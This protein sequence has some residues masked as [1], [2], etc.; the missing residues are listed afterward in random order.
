MT[1]PMAQI[2]RRPSLWLAAMLMV[3]LIL[4]A[5]TQEFRSDSKRFGNSK[6]DIVITETDRQ[7]RTSVV[8]I[9]ITAIG[10]S[11]GSSF[12]LLCSLPDLARER[13]N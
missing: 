7:A 3:M 12:F 10:S 4:P 6:M 5:K 1:L 8:D 2:P 11:I 13:G 9:Q